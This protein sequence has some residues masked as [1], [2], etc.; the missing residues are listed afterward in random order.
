MP[1]EKTEQPTPKRLRDARR[2]GQ[3][4]RSHDF[5]Q[6]FL[7][8]T[9]A[10]VLA[11]GGSAFWRELQKLL[12]GFFQPSL[13]TGELTTDSLLR[14]TGEAWIHTFVLVTPLLGALV[15]VSAGL[16]F[17]QVR[18]LFAPEVIKPKLEKL[19]PLRGLQNMFFQGRTYIELIKN[20]VKFAVIFWLCYSTF[21]SYLR[22]TLLTARLGLP[23]IAE[24]AARLILSLLFKVGAAFVILGA[25]DFLLQK[26]QYLKGLMMTRYEVEKEFKEEEG[27]PQIKQMRKRAHEEIMAE[28]MMEN[29]PR[30]DVVVVNPTHLAVAIRYDEQSMSAP[31]ITAKGQGT[32]AQRLVGIAKDSKVPILRNVPLARSLFG[33][34]V[35][36]EIP[37][38]L[39]EAVAE[40]LNWVYQ[41]AE[42]RV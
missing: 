2:K 34:E 33:L 18:A 17:L 8:L 6:A 22:D 1:G 9:A 31:K 21:R 13:L 38:E 4:F 24:V 11:L 23:Q 29:V 5:T 42:A 32:V 40:V 36:S 26:R 35:G 15:M 20:L 25:A 39:Y 10:G 16:N 37:E 19:N 30:A 27:D 7:F 14:R 3:V 41:M 12:V 28:T